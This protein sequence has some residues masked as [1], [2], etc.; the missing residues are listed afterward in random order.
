MNSG[1][2]S[3]LVIPAAVDDDAAA[4]AAASR[5]TQQMNT[6]LAGVMTA[7][8]RRRSIDRSPRSPAGYIQL[9]IANVSRRRARSSSSS[10]AGRRARRGRGFIRRRGRGGEER[11][12]RARASGGEVGVFHRDT[13][14]RASARTQRQRRAAD[15]VA[16]V[17][18]EVGVGLKLPWS[19]GV[20]SNPE[21]ILYIYGEYVC[22][23]YISLNSI[24]L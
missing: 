1:G 3:A 6:T 17:S 20:F 21:S 13:S 19:R 12:G 5:T 16:D 7:R 4:A 10:V 24:Y 18:R 11:R 2:K 22:V 14:C 15:V 23:L 9:A 8:A